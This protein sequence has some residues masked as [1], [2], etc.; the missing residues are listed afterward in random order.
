MVLDV[1]MEFSLKSRFSGESMELGFPPETLDT[2]CLI[3]DYKFMKYHVHVEG[4]KQLSY[5][6]CS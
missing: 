5:G 2:R 1:Q 4:C 3:L 6:N